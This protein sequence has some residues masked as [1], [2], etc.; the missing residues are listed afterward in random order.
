[1][2]WHWGNKIV[3]TISEMTQSEIAIY[4][5]DSITK[6]ELV[7]F[8]PL[9]KITPAPVVVCNFPSVGCPLAI[10]VINRQ[11]LNV[12]F[13]AT[14]T[15]RSAVCLEDLNLKFGFPDSHV[16]SSTF[17]MCL[18]IF[19]VVG[20]I[21]VGFVIGPMVTTM[22]LWVFVRHIWVSSDSNMD[23]IP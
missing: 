9:V 22:H 20:L 11:K 6:R 18:I 8:Q 21:G 17:S 2:H 13:A 3:G 12:C 14:C 16:F 1:M 23:I 4:A 15:N 7:I 5:Q 19:L 10:D